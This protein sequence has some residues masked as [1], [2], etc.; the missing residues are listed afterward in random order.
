M[1]KARE[2]LLVLSMAVTA[3]SACASSPPPPPA[4]APTPAAASEP[5]PEVGDAVM[6][7]KGNLGLTLS[8]VRVG[9]PE[10]DEV[11]LKYSGID[12]AWSGKVMKAKK[13]HA[14]TGFDY[15]ITQASGEYTTVVERQNSWGS[16]EFFEAYLPGRNPN[17]E[18][19]DYDEKASKEASA[20]SLLSEYLSKKQ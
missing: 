13:V 9:K 10:A 12:H 20:Q 4:A 15:R 16:G 17:G 6:V 1:M 2:G 8:L 14:G 11:L 3:V 19:I 7:F 5:R 18:H